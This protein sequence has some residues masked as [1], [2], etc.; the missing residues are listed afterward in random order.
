MPF[1][2]LYGS[3]RKGCNDLSLALLFG[4]ISVN[5]FAFFHFQMK[6]KGEI[7]YGEYLYTFRVQHAD[8]PL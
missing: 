1:L 2:H 6:S 7:N 8:G 3:G 5:A 4:A